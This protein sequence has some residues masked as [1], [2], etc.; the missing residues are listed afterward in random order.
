M[1][2]KQ[3]LRVINGYRELERAGMVPQLEC[4]L[5]NAVLLHYVNHMADSV[6]FACL[7]CGRIVYPGTAV[8]E[9]MQE[10]VRVN[11]RI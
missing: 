4:E 7:G 5:D 3:Q 2:L 9:Q 6:Y 8:L 11:E 1:D 10:V